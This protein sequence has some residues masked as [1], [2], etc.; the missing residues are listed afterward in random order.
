M[1]AVDRVLMGR[2][3]MLLLDES[4]TGLSSLLAGEIF[5]IISD[6]DESGVTVLLVEWNAEK[7]LEIADYAYVL[8]TGKIVMS[9][10]V[11]E[12]ADNEEVRRAYPGD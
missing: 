7:T 11:L 10:G 5:E 9:G 1:L 8:G 12:L 3:E 6:V 4:F 2:L